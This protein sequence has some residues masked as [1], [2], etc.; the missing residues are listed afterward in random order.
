MKTRV[1]SHFRFLGPKLCRIVRCSS[2]I[3]AACL[4][5]GVL[6]THSPA[7]S[8][9]AAEAGKKEE[10]LTNKSIIELQ[11]LNLGD[12]VIIEKIKASKCD[13]DVSVSGLKQLKEARVSDAVIQTMIAPKPA[14]T[15]EAAKSTA[16]GDSNDPNVPHEAGVWLYEETGGQ[17]KMSRV[18]SESYRMWMGGGPFGGA[19]RA[20]LTGLGA[21]LQLSSRRPTFYL[22]F[23]DA[24]QGILGATSPNELPLARFTLKEKTKERLLVVG[25]VAPFAGY[26]SGIEAK[27]L[28]AVEETRVAPGIYKVVPKEDLSDGEYGF[29][30]AIAG[31]TAGRMFCFGVRAK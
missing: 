8:T 6:G 26:N 24:R 7:I 29:C 15:V 4:C 12:V 5:V 9:C 11:Q 1:N 16:A 18:E 28:R 20:V 17:K 3:L 23:G 14:A 2:I 30:Q 27:A 22:Y 19:S 10:T 21:S 25:R 31:M 13:F